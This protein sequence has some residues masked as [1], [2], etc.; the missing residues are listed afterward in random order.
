L[1]PDWL[2]VI[3]LARRASADPMDFPAA[4]EVVNRL[5][6][7]AANRDSVHLIAAP[8]VP[9]PAHDHQ[10]PL[11]SVVICS[12][13]RAKFAAVTRMYEQLLPAASL[14]IIGIHDARGLA[15][16]Y[17]RGLRQSRGELII[18]SHDDIEIHCADFGARLTDALQ[19]FD[20]IGVVGATQ[21]TGPGVKWAGHPH[22]R[23]WITHPTPDRQGW[24][25]GVHRIEHQ[26]VAGIQAIDGL[27][28]ATKKQVAET[29][30]FDEKVE[31]F[32]FYDLDFSWRA[33]KAGFALGLEPS[34][35]II[36]DSLGNFGPAWQRSASS[37]Q[38]LHPELAAPMGQHLHAYG[39]AFK[40]KAAAL[41]FYDLLA[42]AVENRHV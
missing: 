7:L 24:L 19:R 40:E 10:L 14:E 2:E 17:N 37:F 16:A 28:M 18:F 26:P 36:H 9:A 41:R 23:G 34:I 4:Q 32:H 1:A 8:F 11:V 25:A 15:E 22:I 38:A 6:I 12:I 13:D 33:A 3:R 20:L 29:V 31:G 30:L 35:R 42:A 5:A 21:V 39:A 27:W